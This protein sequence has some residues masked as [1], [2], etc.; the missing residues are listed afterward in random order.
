M[1]TQ[2]PNPNYLSKGLLIIAILFTHL[3]TAQ[4]PKSTINLWGNAGLSSS[5]SS[6]TALLGCNIGLNTVINQRYYL[7]LSNYVSINSEWEL[8]SPAQPNKTEN[9]SNNA[10]LAGIYQQLSKRIAVVAAAGPS[11]GQLVYRGEI[12]SIYYNYST[13]GIDT[14]TRT[15]DMQTIN[16]KGLQLE[17]TLILTS[18]NV[19]MS[20]NFFA[21]LHPHP[22]FGLSL[23]L[24]LG[25]MR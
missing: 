23:N 19:G 24:L 13:W 18:P 22:D 3:G 11:F 6:N 10:F 21:N 14:E 12:Q 9:I 16:Y 15:F 7:H 5:Q 17:T 4:T 2:Y 1:K 20:I 25:K 8:F